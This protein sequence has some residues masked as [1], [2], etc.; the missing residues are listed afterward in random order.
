MRRQVDLRKKHGDYP[1]SVLEYVSS[2]NE[3]RLVRLMGTDAK[4]GA[5]T[6][7]NLETIYI[8]EQTGRYSH[9]NKKCLPRICLNRG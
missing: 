3:G 4:S 7:Y 1:I 2:D 5:I 9:S 8:F 6:E